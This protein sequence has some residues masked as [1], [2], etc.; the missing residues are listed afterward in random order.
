MNPVAARLGA[1]PD[2]AMKISGSSSWGAVR[3]AAE[4]HAFGASHLLLSEYCVKTPGG[5]ESITADAQTHDARGL[6]V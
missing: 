1:W 4:K 6:T 5:G 3:C 2:G